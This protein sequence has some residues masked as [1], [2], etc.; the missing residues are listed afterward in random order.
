MGKVY[1]WDHV[2]HKIEST[3]DQL[4]YNKKE[5]TKAGQGKK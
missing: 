2:Q 3:E 5:Y 1:K 4:N